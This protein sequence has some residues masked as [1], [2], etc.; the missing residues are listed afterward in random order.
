MAIVSF[1]MKA[2]IAINS[3][4]FGQNAWYIDVSNTTV[5][6]TSGFSYDFDQRLT[7]IYNSGVKY[8]RIGG[9]NTNFKPLYNFNAT[10]FA[11]T[12]AP[13]L[14]HLIDV[15][16][17]AGMEPIIEVGYNPLCSLITPL[18][19]ITMA[20]Q[21]KIAGNLIDYLNNPTTGFYPTQSKPEV[22]N[23]II[24][25]EPDHTSS[26]TDNIYGGDGGF[27]YDN[28][29]TPLL[30]TDAQH[31]ADYIQAFSKAM[32]DG[33][34]ASQDL[35]IIG[36]ELS[37]FN[38]DNGYSTNLLMNDLISNPSNTYSIMG[39]IGGT[40]NGAGKYFID[41]ISFHYYIGVTSA[42]FR[43]DI[44]ASP[45]Q[46]KNGFTNDLY[47]SGYITTGNCSPGITRKGIVNMIT[48]NSTGRTLTDIGIVCD[49]LNLLSFSS[50]TPKDE[51][52]DYANMI[53]DID[54]RSYLG[55]QWMAEVLCLGMNGA[56]NSAWVRFMMPWSVQE[57]G[58]RP[59]PS[60]PDP[61]LGGLGYI[62][63]CGA[64]NK[65][66][67]YWHYQM[68]ANNFSG[69]YYANSCTTN[70]GYYKAFAYKNATDIGVLIMNQDLQTTPT[71]GTDFTTTSF[72][73]NFNNSVPSSGTMNFAFSTGNTVIGTG[74]TYSCKIMKETTMLLV[75]DITTG[76]LKKRE[77]YSL[78]DALRT[79]DTGTQTDIVSNVTPAYF[80]DNYADRTPLYSDI[81]IGTNSSTTITAGVNK[82]F[83]ATNTIQLNGPY[84]S[85][86]K[87]LVLTIDHTS[88]P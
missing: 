46:C 68:V 85:N 80:Y 8:I 79:T 62:S 59:T 67:E 63:N 53:E 71:R 18:G 73:I 33:A 76:A 37:S 36:P 88:C 60:S 51:S 43:A 45:T 21:A 4:F 29:T 50:Y 75:F 25:N 27:S 69:T 32:K 55:G 7:D 39:T 14:T 5:S 30:H 64:K 15:I 81:T 86:G 49:E 31:I 26:C 9:I 44:I 1:N 35:T 65:R 38:A 41:D 13:R 77:T 74:G 70:A 19:N 17:A 84:S 78:Q 57:S 28:T 12:S 87:Q 10:T 23:W 40:G 3:T 34:D 54:S 61:C 72:A 52:S 48:G 24:A 42:T 22:L 16:R 56:N 6:G 11:I 58:N 82:T 47:S 20:N 66:P 83:T 2:Q